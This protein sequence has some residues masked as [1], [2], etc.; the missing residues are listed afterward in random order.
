MNSL[1]LCQ[2]TYC[3]RSHVDSHIYQKVP[4]SHGQHNPFRL[5]PKKK[6]EKK[7][8]KKPPAAAALAFLTGNG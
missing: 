8:T 1:S 7:N 5:S 3:C 6:K 2:L 4:D